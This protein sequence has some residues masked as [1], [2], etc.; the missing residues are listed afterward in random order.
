MRHCCPVD[1][2]R[3]PFTRN[4]RNL[5]R[6]LKDPIG[7]FESIQ[8]SV[9][10][11]ITSA[12]A[13]DSLTFEARR[14]DL[15]DKSGVLFQEPFLEPIPS[16]QSGKPLSSLS[17]AD[18]PDLS[19]A[20]IDAFKGIIGA[21][22]FSG[23]H[24]LYLHQQRMLKASLEG[25]HCVVVTGTGSGKTETFLLPVLAS[26]IK[27]AKANKGGWDDA[28]PPGVSWSKETP[29]NWMDS[30]RELQRETRPAAI[31]S[32]ILYP[33]NAL[34]EDQLSRLRLALDTDNAHAE[35]DAL[36][37]GNRIRFGRYNGATPVAGHPFKSDGKSNSSTRGRLKKALSAAIAESQGIQEKIRWLHAQLQEASKIGDSDKMG[38]I[39][40][41]LVKA[42]HESSFI[43]RLEPGACEMFHRW[44]MQAAP[45]DLLITN[46]SMLSI[47][48]MRHKDISIKGDCAD[49]QMF[50][51]TR[52]WLAGD[53]E[54][55]FQLVVDELHLYRGTAG[56][57]VGYLLRLLLDRLGLKPDS[58]Q[59]RILASS[60]SLDK[61]QGSTFEF[62]G[63]FFGMNKE[64]AELKFHVE[65]GELL[66]QSPTEQ[67]AFD[68]Q[69]SKVCLE[70][71]EQAFLKLD[72]ADPTLVLSMLAQQANVSEKIVAAFRHLD[73]GVRARSLQSVADQWFPSLVDERLRRQAARG[74]FVAVGSNKGE[75]LPIPRLRFHW[76]AKNVDGLWAT[77]ALHGE[78]PRRRVGDLTPEPALSLGGSRLLEVLYCECCGT[79]LL[80]GN[81][82][83]LTTAQ[84]R[85]SGSASQFP[86]Q[87]AASPIAYELTALPIMIEGVPEAVPN[88]RTDAQLYKNLGVVWLF[89]PAWAMDNEQDYEWQQGT[90][91]RGDRGNRLGG[92]KAGWRRAWINPFTGIVSLSSGHVP[93]TEEI[94]CLWFATDN[95]AGDL[96]LP[97][98]PQR[99]PSCRIDYS[100]R[101]GRSSPI[102]SFVTGLGVMSHLLAKHLMGVLPSDSRKLVAFSDSREAAASLAAGVEVLQWEHLFR[103]TLHRE[104]RGRALDGFDALKHRLLLASE[105]LDEGAIDDMLNAA[106]LRMT[107]EEFEEACDFANLAGAVTRHP[108]RATI[109][110]KAAIQQ[111]RDYQPGYVYLDDLVTRPS[112]QNVG[113]PPVWREMVRYGINPGGPSIEQRSFMLQDRELR[114]WTSIFE[115]EGET[116]VARLRARSPAV[117]A[118][119][120][121]LGRGLRMAAWRSLSGR[122]LYDLE[123]QGLGYLCF[124]PRAK[125][126]PVKGMGDVPFREVCDSVLR[127]L[128]QERWT[129]PTQRDFPQDGFTDKQPT[130]GARG[131][132]GKQVF[133]Y[134][135]EVAKRHGVEVDMLRDAVRGAF[136]ETGHVSQSGGWGVVRL[137]K[138]WV[139]VVA[140]DAC[141]WV[142]NA[143]NQIQWHA[144]A[145]ICSRCH[146]H[147]AALPDAR[148]K[149][150]SVSMCHYYA[151]EAADLD[152][153]FRIHAE[154]LTGQTLNQ[155]QRQRHFRD[156]FFQGEKLDDIVTREVLENVD[157][158]DLLS[159]TTTM[160]VGVDIGSLQ[161]VMQANMPPERFNYQQRAGRAGRNKQPFSA[162]L[163]FCRGQS[164]DRIHFEHPEEMTGG[165]PPQPSVATG[166]EQ[167]I[168]AERLVAKEVLRRS[169]QSLG[170]SWAQT[171]GRDIHGELGTVA[172]AVAQMPRF[173]KWL[174]A[175]QN[176]V[177]HI[178]STI[179][180]GTRVNVKSLID[181]AN[182]LRVR[183]EN[184]LAEKVFV[185]PTLAFR[186]AEAG[187]LPMYGMPTSVRSLY[188]S[189][190]SGAEEEPKTLD[191]PFDQAVAEFVPGSERT[192]DKRKVTPVGLCGDVSF[193]HGAGSG[194]RTSGTPIGA[195][196]AQ[197]FCPDCRSL[198]VSAADSDTL[199][200]GDAA[201]WWRPEFLRE[202]KFAT[203]PSCGGNRARPFMAIAPRAFISDLDIGKSAKRWDSKVPRAGFPVVGSPVLS[204]N[205]RYTPRLGALV[206]LARQAQ[207]FRTN[208][209]NTN[210]FGFSDAS[211]IRRGT[212][213]VNGEMG[214]IW[215][216]T[217]DSPQRKVAITSPKTTDLLAVRMLDGAGLEFFDTDGDI[218]C[219]RAAW[220]SAATILQ[221]AIALELDVDSLDIEIASV[222]LIQS[223]SEGL[224]R[225]GEL[226]LADAHPNGAGIVEWAN[227][228]W[229]DL[230]EGCVFGTGR[231]SLMGRTIRSAW[232][233]SETEP[234]RG[235]DTLLRGFRNAP[236]HGLLDWQL[237]LEMLATLIDP[238]YRPGLDSIVANRAGG[239]ATLPDWQ[240]LTTS[241]AARYISAFPNV[242]PLP[243]GAPV[244]GWVA[245]GEPQ[246]ATVVLHP[247]TAGYEG[248][249]NAL[250]AVKAWGFS[251]GFVALRLV[252][253]F[254]LSRR[255]AWV[256]VN[257]EKF[258]LVNLD[259]NSETGDTG[260][261]PYV[262]FQ[263]EGNELL[264]LGKKYE[265]IS[266][267]AAW[268]APKGDWLARGG[269]GMLHAIRVRRLPGASSPI[270]QEG[271]SAFSEQAAKSLVLVGRL[272]E[273]LKG[274]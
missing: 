208:T 181:S 227:E 87:G 5:E 189:F 157:S 158:I 112:A 273:P 251:N 201:S 110:A 30:R 57:E 175:N 255:M 62:L 94:N 162:A 88:R 116:L 223:A 9:K 21:G 193:A 2:L 233:M 143:C 203:C 183:I 8:S 229:E 182:A 95:T 124:P 244:A 172:G 47:M 185:E 45:P 43:P 232:L 83:A 165:I 211:Y 80:C 108:N 224:A 161:S 249:R 271:A 168:L 269:N 15:L 76:M 113:L 169:F 131:T 97:A 79:Q 36:L 155:A 241:L 50:D 63:G 206:A 173:S 39:E 117:L 128:S 228:N 178:C 274:I 216:H 248:R 81:K 246:I 92:A 96:D 190:P 226:Y 17:L 78:D 144:S 167:R 65:P 266:E 250:A 103:A 100:E 264:Y 253:S 127:I 11:Y 115:I 194:W 258:I 174:A 139:K 134:L 91:E 33:M 16:Y 146:T 218:S 209:N 135:G 29:P 52:E 198:Q 196:Y 114:D 242:S 141:P 111:A 89:P 153:T 213:A 260:T 69:F 202:K 42:N 104:L 221:R 220:Y 166:D 75:I 86:E 235:P 265:K 3:T 32:L 187:I 101:F 58:P 261:Q 27:E 204:E 26:I 22:L 234:W 98:M 73:G 31:R 222:H 270:V 4:K 37:G 177:A 148:R 55:V 118:G 164:H 99:C 197:L 130:K 61:G 152:A 219:R 195:A 12:F 56:T 90:E 84:L 254:N 48:L 245:V 147:L 145:G 34:V 122:L 259:S 272:L 239:Q 156:V 176:A 106:E 240:L 207:V 72:V 217:G 120:D 263:N 184:A 200:V 67:P 133:R 214:A 237:G 77:P 236:L 24:P 163:T 19:T 268:T 247:L 70:L 150:S 71:G 23:G 126:S 151:R 225:G 212:S 252:D 132:A 159:V 13:T 54:R 6:N 186:L 107:S 267:I 256:R 119:L 192:W 171:D 64:E 1:G 105:S 40:R 59:L 41:Q 7:A 191:R 142:C 257:I 160:E 215:R 243:A 82:I 179:A 28:S 137:D 46:V 66:Y 35:M 230:L 38:A 74:L 123:S 125:L 53:E 10:R 102:R 140:P 51:M 149:A 109:S 138:L 25:K 262:F 18:M 136:R 44:E 121:S 188:F 49:S 129:E 170:V 238:N 14:K 93:V 180:S 85:G 60:A 20:A 68:M 210:L 199:E 154:E 231:N 205:T